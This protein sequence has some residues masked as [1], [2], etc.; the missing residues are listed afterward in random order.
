MFLHRLHLNLRSKE[1]R[2]D[3]A[4]PYQLHATL[5]R[6]FS[7]ADVPCPPGAFLWRLE[8]ETDTSGAARILV[9]SRELPEWDRIALKDWLE[10]APDPAVDLRNRLGLDHLHVGQHFRFRLRANPSAIKAGRRVGLLKP[11]DQEA[12]LIRKGQ[13]QHGF[14]LLHQDSVD[15]FDGADSRP[16]IRTSQPQTL[17]GRQVSGNTIQIF[18]ALFDGTLQVTHPDAFRDALARGIG[19]GKALGLGLLSVVPLP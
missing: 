7:P 16:D 4:D 10:R 13:D 5:S 19:H 12:W 9:Q 6:A 2:R 18:S 14:E 1:A 3:L 11:E 15:F 8:P 17:R